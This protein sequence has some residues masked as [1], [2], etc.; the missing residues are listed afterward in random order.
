MDTA[1]LVAFLIRNDTPI[2][3][4]G[5]ILLPAQPVA[6][7]ALVP[8]TTGTGAE[9]TRIAMVS[10][11][12]AKRIVNCIQFVP[13]V[14][15]LDPE[16]VADLPAP[17]VSATALDAL[18]HA[19][20]SGL[21][22]TRTPATIALG[23]RAAEILLDNVVA[24]VVDG[25]A[26]AKGQLL[27]GAYLAGLSL[28]A[29][30]VLG[31]SLGYVIARRAHLSH[32]VSCALALPYCL[33]YNQGID[34]EHASEIARLVGGDDA[35][36]ASAAQS[37]SALAKRLS[38]PQSLSEVGIDRSELDAM[39]AETVRDYPRPNNPVPLEEGRVLQL[40]L[41]MYD[42]DI[43]RASADMAEVVA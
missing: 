5:G 16:L 24:A 41:G 23:K 11:D 2:D 30:V 42:G 14:A 33:A 3:S 25:E 43:E 8:T 39:A 13:L 37:L 10:I 28:N 18:A 40:L 7:L 21:S 17:V 34:R 20:E 12:G 31:H 27:Y 19:L 35:S 1:K 29:G 15:A 26:D 38:L 9:A 4:L 36:L 22:S 32:G 6:H